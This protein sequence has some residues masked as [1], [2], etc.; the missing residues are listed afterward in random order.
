VPVGSDEA[1]PGPTG[2]PEPAPVPA[3]KSKPSK[4]TKAAP[5]TE[6]SKGTTRTTFI[7]LSQCRDCTTDAS[8]AKEATVPK[9]WFDR[10]EFK[11]L[12]ENA[13]TEG[14]ARREAQ[15]AEQRKARRLEAKRTAEAAPE[16]PR[17]DTEDGKQPEPP[18]VV[19]E[20]QKQRVCVVAHK[21]RVKLCTKTAFA[22][23]SQEERILKKMAANKVKQVARKVTEERK[24]VHAAIE[25]A[26]WA[27]TPT[28][29]PPKQRAKRNDGDGKCS[30]DDDDEDGGTVTVTRALTLAADMCYNGSDGR[31]AL[32]DFAAQYARATTE[33]SRKLVAF[34]LKLMQDGKGDQLEIADFQDLCRWAFRVTQETTYGNL[35]S[36]LAQLCVVQN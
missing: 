14:N 4:K 1:M 23:M 31:K 13:K 28:P 32:R 19:K 16:A 20:T 18:P 10:L 27:P 25:A 21:N 3:A 33:G 11:S 6:E 15:K 22:A 9:S 12:L 8:D 36:K 26:F 5:P 17:K 30:N 7:P 24:R 35:K 2:E 29:P 34:A